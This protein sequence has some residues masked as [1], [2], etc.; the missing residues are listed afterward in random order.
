LKQNLANCQNAGDAPLRHP[1]KLVVR[2]VS[3]QRTTSQLAEKP[4][5]ASV[6]KGHGLIRADRIRKMIAG[7][8]P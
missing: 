6:L 5:G 3:S 1:E 2:R 4:L 7:F 8:S